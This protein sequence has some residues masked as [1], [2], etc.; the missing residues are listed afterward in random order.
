MQHSPYLIGIDLGTTNSSLAYIDRRTSKNKP[1]IFSIPQ[2]VKPGVVEKLQML[3]SFLYFPAEFEW[4]PEP[5]TLPLASEKFSKML[6]GEIAKRQGQQVP[7]R[8]VHSAKSWLCH[9]AVDRHAKILPWGSPPEIPKISP[10]EASCAYLEYLKEAWN[11]LKAKQETERLEHQEIVLTVPASFDEVAREL[12]VNAAHQAGLK[13]ITLLEEPMAA[14]YYWI[15]SYESNWPKRF[16]EKCRHSGQLALVCDIGGG[17][18]DFSLIEIQSNQGSFQFER[19]A[20]GEHLLLGGNNMDLALAVHLEQTQTKRKMTSRELGELI[21]LCSLAKEE[22]FSSSE[23]PS[24]AFSLLARG[25]SV[26]ESS[27]KFELTLSDLETVILSGFF[28]LVPWEESEKKGSVPGFREFGLPYASDPSITRHLRKFLKKHLPP[29][30]LVDLI[31]FN[32]GALIPQKIR[33]Q[34]LTQ[35]SV[36]FSEKSDKNWNPV[37]LHNKNLH[38]AVAY[39]AAYFNW[40]R[41][42]QGIRIT[43]GSPRAYFLEV[44]AL[45]KKAQVRSAL[46][47]LP[48]GSKEGTVFKIE[49]PLFEVITRR[50]VSFPLY[51]STVRKQDQVGDLVEIREDEMT[52][53]APVQTILQLGRKSKRDQIPVKL[54]AQ[55]TEIGLLE[56]WLSATESE[57]R[58][59]LQFS[60]TDE[61][62][63]SEATTEKEI[64]P[65]AHFPKNEIQSILAKTFQQTSDTEYTPE[66]LP[67]HLERSLALSKE[68]WDLGIV[69][70][71]WDLLFMVAPQRNKSPEHEAR[72]LNLI[73]FCLRPGNGVLGDEQRIKKIW[74]LLKDK[75]CF[76]RNIQSRVENWILWRR[77]SAGLNANQQLELFHKMLILKPSS[78]N[79]SGNVYLSPQ[80]VTEIWRTFASLEYLPLSLRIEMGD[81]LSKKISKRPKEVKNYEFWA[82]G[83]IGARTPLYA[84]MNRVVPAT[85][86]QQWIEKLLEIEESR[87]EFFYT[88]A[89]LAKKCGDRVLDIEEPLRE[90]LLKRF[91]AHPEI[92]GISALSQMLKEVVTL[93]PSLQKHYFGDSLP[94]GIIISG[95]D[96]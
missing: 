23:L 66:L 14:F 33:D 8:S 46:C 18:T 59:K 15:A 39:G 44:Q 78:E 6:L 38:L 92:A 21:G 93:N 56:L 11:A 95:G 76:E 53:L 7:I 77:V 79:R 94:P 42:G 12:T 9:T 29:D 96:G 24:K 50:P 74:P 1:A 84:K 49:Q 43:G 54:E 90:K 31:L 16:Q 86:V 75:V 80:E 52:S 63:D 47:L 45:Q 37:V 34:I 64:T 71:L 72:W 91:E 88:L 25:S 22:L 27:L 73:G 67:D 36:W 19:F 87:G 61:P 70:Q 69:R 89:E 81:S 58:W 17:T 65:V 4:K 10:I 32:G 51:E 57:H 20:V 26:I 55:M 30:R 41:S 13:K 35:L 40:V 60:M 28:P 62:N 3:P 5:K 85:K 48:F 83:R 82:L 68:S 2:L